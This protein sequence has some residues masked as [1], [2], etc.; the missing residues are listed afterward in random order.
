MNGRP[1]RLRDG[2]EELGAGAGH[3]SARPAVDGAAG[4]FPGRREPAEMVQPHHVDLG[5]RRAKR[6]T[7]QRYPVR[8]RTSQS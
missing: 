1:P 4:D 7:H 5:Q 3:P 6:S 8:R 2:L